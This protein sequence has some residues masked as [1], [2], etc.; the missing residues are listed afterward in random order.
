MKQQV[1]HS[2]GNHCLADIPLQYMERKN[3]PIRFTNKSSNNIHLLKL[4]HSTKM[5][6]NIVLKAFA[7]LLY[8]CVSSSIL[9]CTCL[10]SCGSM[11]QL[12]CKIAEELS[13]NPVI[14]FACKIPV[15]EE[16]E[17]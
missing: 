4:K 11:H 13:D 6:A 12:V 7:L 8:S 14:Q 9:Q 3:R 10:V 5:S 1:F 15:G 16:T 17:N 2:D